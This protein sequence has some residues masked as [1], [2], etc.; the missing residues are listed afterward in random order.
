MKIHNFI[1][2]SDAWLMAR[3]GVATC[4]EFSKII[5]SEG[6]TSTQHKAYA[7][8]LASEMLATEQ[9]ETFTNKDMERG[10]ELEPEAREAYQESCFCEVEEVGFMS[11]EN[12]GYSPDGLV[13]K[14]GIIEIKCPKQTTHT[15]YLYEDRLP[16]EYKAQENG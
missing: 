1:Q 15:K 7:L 9:E 12:W 10:N 8:K 13:D 16:I 6:K 11:C 4:S 14:E 2:G 5:T 3:L